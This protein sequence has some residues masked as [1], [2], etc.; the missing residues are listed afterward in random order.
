[1]SAHM[2]R[3]EMSLIPDACV[4]KIAFY[5]DEKLSKQRLI[6]LHINHNCFVF[7]INLMNPILNSDPNIINNHN[8]TQHRS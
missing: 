5:E 8:V 7:P 4:M 3:P 6:T 2:T 1:M